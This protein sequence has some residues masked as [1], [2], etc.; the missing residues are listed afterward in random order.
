MALLS[1]KPQDFDYSL[2]SLGQMEGYGDDP[3]ATAL[4]FGNY[5]DLPLLTEGF[6]APKLTGDQKIKF[7]NITAEIVKVGGPNANVLL[8]AKGLLAANPGDTKLQN[9]LLGVLGISYTGP[10]NF[11][12]AWE[13]IKIGLMTGDAPG[14]ALG[15]KMYRQELSKLSS[16]L[17]PHL[18]K[19]PLGQEL[20][21]GAQDPVKLA[22]RIASLGKQISAEGLSKG[23]SALGA[24]AL[25]QIYGMSYS[26]VKQGMDTYLL[27]FLSE[28]T[29]VRRVYESATKTV[30]LYKDLETD[31][32]S[33]IKK[34][35]LDRGGE[36]DATGI[37][38]CGKLVQKSIL[39]VGSFARMVGGEKVGKAAD[40]IAAWAGV[41]TGCA[42]G[43]AAGAATGP[44]G[45][46]AGAVACGVAVLTKA[47]N[48]FF[49]TRDDPYDEKQAAVFMPY[50]PGTSSS[51]AKV[52]GKIDQ[53]AAVGMDAERLSNILANY[54]DFKSYGKHAN[55]TTSGTA[56]EYGASH[57]IY[58]RVINTDRHAGWFVPTS[59]I[60]PT[61]GGA[62]RY[63]SLATLQKPGGTKPT[64]FTMITALNALD[65]TA[66]VGRSGL[67]TGAAW[68]RNLLFIFAGPARATQESLVGS[69]TKAHAPRTSWATAASKEDSI[70]SRWK[71]VNAKAIE[72]MASIARNPFKLEKAV[73]FL[74]AYML[75][76]KKDRTQNWLEDLVEAVVDSAADLVDLFGIASSE[77]IID[78]LDLGDF[79]LP[80]GFDADLTQ[81][82]EARIRAWVLEQAPIAFETFRRMDALLNFFAAMTM[83]ETRRG[84]EETAKTGTPI[85]PA[86]EP[87]INVEN[88]LPIVFYFVG[89][90][91]RNPDKADEDAYYKWCWTNLEGCE[92][93][94]KTTEKVGHG[95]CVAQFKKQLMANN[96]FCA[97][98]ELAVI[99][100]LSAF[101]FIH[102]QYVGGTQR[103]EVNDLIEDAYLEATRV[104]K[105]PLGHL[106]RAI[107]PRERKAFPHSKAK[108]QV[109][110][111][112]AP[113][114]PGAAPGASTAYMPRPAAPWRGPRDVG[115]NPSGKHL[116]NSG[117]P[118]DSVTAIQSAGF[119]TDFL[120]TWS[121][122][123]QPHPMSPPRGSGERISM[124]ALDTGHRIASLYLRLHQHGVVVNNV[125]EKAR[126]QAHID[127]RAEM[128]LS[129]VRVL[130]RDEPR[131]RQ[132]TIKI[133]T[134]ILNGKA[135]FKTS[136]T[137]LGKYA[138]HCGKMRFH[139]RES[140]PQ[141]FAPYATKDWKPT[142]CPAP[143]LNLN[144]EWC[145]HLATKGVN[146]ST[147]CTDPK[148][149]IYDPKRVQ[150]F[151][152]IFKHHMLTEI[153][154]VRNLTFSVLNPK[155]ALQGFGAETTADAKTTA[156]D[157]AY[158]LR[159]WD[160]YLVYLKK[161]KDRRRKKY[162]LIGGGALAAALVA[163]LAIKG[164]VF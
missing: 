15:K 59:Q 71:D 150:L 17:P 161:A 151:A 87:Y 123:H 79:D 56:S 29:D 111:F 1:L 91:H 32:Q 164:D 6:G 52:R 104:S 140:K 67:N 22:Q 63:P 134:K 135:D 80:A 33:L 62:G 41:L 98:K 24:S 39:A 77:K 143:V 55:G 139:D 45:A 142:C 23:A 126:I 54:Y 70:Y 11:E 2:P 35:K 13:K 138:A 97:A 89:K 148:Q 94:R 154:T 21:A 146:C 16:Q 147:V 19:S 133:A 115:W 14:V 42:T 136:M 75:G 118:Q 5:V 99:R 25:T 92:I 95:N 34:Y 121:R 46:A 108:L 90:N 48:D 96:D 18:A 127:Q 50:S 12:N 100:V 109:H 4:T 38:D 153:P 61:A 132:D 129:L 76:Y 7:D 10:K 20:L 69:T 117:R 112:W 119:R 155:Y 66:Y 114:Q 141:S 68:I 47:I 120:K 30:T 40:Q 144:K 158:Y 124:Q 106:T 128:T 27:P 159:S 130:L 36:M 103:G 60:H 37:A 28:N 131:L 73:Q 8:M 31:T 53:V 105:D 64:G 162:L 149:Y 51:F 125:R 160:E 78:A 137:E 49:S 26:N 145:K 107:D 44:W 81:M 85:S 88:G 101:S 93:R 113:G 110:R 65:K 74:Q 83:Y 82:S 102:M 163:G 43:I 58:Y 157:A 122:I 3:A 57:S 9:E 72:H 84:L 86:W 116:Y 156:S 152:M